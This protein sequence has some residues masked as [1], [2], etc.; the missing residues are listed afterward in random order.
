[1]DR[2][3]IASTADNGKTWKKVSPQFLASEE[4]D[5]ALVAAYHNEELPN[6]GTVR[7]MGL[8][9]FSRGFAL[10]QRWLNETRKPNVRHSARGFRDAE[11]IEKIDA[12]LRRRVSEANGAK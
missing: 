6:D 7:V 4:A 9:E 3:I 11:D 2:Y 5:L 10:G 12:W 1:M 8:E